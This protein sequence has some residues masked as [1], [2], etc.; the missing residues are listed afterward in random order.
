MYILGKNKKM[1][2]RSVQ[3]KNIVALLMSLLL[4]ACA[5]GPDFV[6]PAAPDVDLYT[7][8]EKTTVTVSAEG[9]HQRFQFGEKIAADWWHL[10]K[11]D[12]LN[13][14]VKQAIANSPNLQS[15]QSSLRQ[16][17]DN[18][19]AGYGVFFPE[20]NAN[21]SAIRQKPSPYRFGG[22]SP[23]G[24]F[25]LF[26]LGATVSY[27]LDVFGGNRRM[28]E[29][30]A[31]EVDYQRYAML[32]TYMTLSG[33]VVNTMI[34]RA[35]YQA[36]LEA[37][38][39]MIDL[40]KDQLSITQTQAS[41]G[42]VPYANVLSIQSQLAANEAIL[43]ALRQKRDQATHLLATLSG[44]LPSE[45]TVPMAN[46]NKLTLPQN[47]PISLP[48][49]FARQRPD[50]L[51]A[52]AQLHTASANIG[53]VTAELFPSF[54]L[55]GTYGLINTKFGNLFDAN[56][57]FWSV[58]PTVNIPIFQG[59]ALW[60]RRKAAINAYQKSLADYRQTVL[61][62]FQQVADTLKALEHDAQ[63]LR[64]QSDALQAA[65]EALK[66]R[67]ANY[68][69]GVV[70]YLEVLAANTQFYQ[71]KIGYLQILAQRYQD[72]TA[73]FVAL[74]GGWWNDPELETHVSTENLAEPGDRHP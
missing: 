63:S 45:N 20:I 29:G 9:Q 22:N 61:S 8:G 70:S 14:A 68:R 46:L 59:G 3:G 17:Q 60:Y 5:V 42:I 35:A 48:S 74:G 39:R 40:Q 33:N 31:A 43:P 25:N 15:A 65:E 28:I 7:Q 54:S 38:E 41:A 16:S 49:E 23:T 69:A 21:F 19:R 52:E 34:A 53:V 51:A 11:S 64:A 36:Q 1:V 58:G 67:E 6:R 50:I 37:T 2:W 44:H 66:I 18:L 30:L 24:V 56:S 47:L 73:L 55:S 26:T 27:S 32:G 13:A 72:T 10:F 71:A 57:K 62:A 12:E 4:A